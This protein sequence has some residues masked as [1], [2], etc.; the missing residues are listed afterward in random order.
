MYVQKFLLFVVA[1]IGSITISGCNKTPTEAL[2][3]M[4]SPSAVLKQSGSFMGQGG[5]AVSGKAQIYFEN[6]KYVLK[7][8]D[9][10]SDNGPDLKVYL[11]KEVSPKDQISFGALK[12][13]R[14]NQ[15]YEFSSTPDFMQY[16]FV[17]IHCERY[18]HRYG[19][20]E[21]MP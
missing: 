7:L 2:D 9:F 11:S 16:R 1:A 8:T 20:A 6:N 4:V 17:L 13:T 12:S 3:E 10:Q 21:L 15:V 19:S 14:G 5:Q 18:N